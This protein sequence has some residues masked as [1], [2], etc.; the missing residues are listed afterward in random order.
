MT[1]K[2]IS[3][4][5]RDGVLIDVWMDSP[6]MDGWREV[7]VRWGRKRHSLS[8]KVGWISDCGYDRDEEFVEHW[9]GATAK[10]WM[11]RPEPPKET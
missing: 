10:Y 7:D 11:E 6:A 2:P 1:W 4:A 9:F 5:P 3:S 8:E